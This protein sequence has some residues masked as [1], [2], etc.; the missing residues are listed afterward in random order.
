[1]HYSVAICTC[2][3]EK[4]L[5]DQLS[6]QQADISPKSESVSAIIQSYKSAVPDTPG[7]WDMNF[8]SN[9]GFTTILYATMMH[10]N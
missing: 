1:M 10:I 7:D 9:R 4:Y 6:S 3:W 8:N 5:R 2:N